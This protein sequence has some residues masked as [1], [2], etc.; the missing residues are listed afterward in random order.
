L[1]TSQPSEKA[2]A[3]GEQPSA[4]APQKVGSSPSTRPISSHSEIALPSFVNREPEAIGLTIRS[5]SL[6]PSCSI[7]S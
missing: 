7:V 3:T 2:V 5:G 1:Q 6:Q 4:W